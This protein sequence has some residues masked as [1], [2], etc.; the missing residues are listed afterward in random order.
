MAPDIAEGESAG[1][2][3]MSGDVTHPHLVGDELGQFL[4]RHD[5]GL[6]DASW[7]PIRERSAQPGY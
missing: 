1:S 2:L 7:V 3:H 4:K 5:S 6:V